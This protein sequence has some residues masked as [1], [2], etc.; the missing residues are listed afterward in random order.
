MPP[1]PPACTIQPD[2]IKPFPALAPRGAAQLLTS[3]EL[4]NTQWFCGC[5]VNPNPKP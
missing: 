3:A 4:M 5:P 2:Y 1:T